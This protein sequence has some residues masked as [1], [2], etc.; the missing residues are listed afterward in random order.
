MGGAAAGPLYGHREGAG[1]RGTVGHNGQRGRRRSVS[2][3]SDGRWAEA[4][5]RQHLVA[6]QVENCE[7]HSAVEPALAGYCHRVGG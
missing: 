5:S 1:E 6:R 2:R 4:C 3:R 7:R